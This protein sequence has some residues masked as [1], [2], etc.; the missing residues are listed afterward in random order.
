MAVCVSWSGLHEGGVASML[1]RELKERRGGDLLEGG[2]IKLAREN[3]GTSQHHHYYYYHYYKTVNF[4]WQR[5]LTVVCGRSPSAAPVVLG[6]GG[7]GCNGWWWWLGGQV[8]WCCRPLR[9]TSMAWAS[10]PHVMPLNS[11]PSANT[12]VSHPSRKQQQ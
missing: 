11:W 2:K 4:L 9:S 3:I 10:T 6:G 7:G 5:A 8:W 1:P 12:P